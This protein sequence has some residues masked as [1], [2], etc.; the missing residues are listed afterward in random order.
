MLNKQSYIKNLL[1]LNLAVLFIS[2]S[3]VLGRYIDLPVPFIIFARALLAGF[4]LFSYAKYKG[5]NFTIDSKDKISLLIGGAFLG[6]H[7][8]TYFYALKLSNVAI[9]LI[10]LYTFPVIT[11]ILEPIMLKQKIQKV[12]LMLGLVVLIGI[13]FIVPDFNLENRYFYGI[14][15][16][17]LSAVL[18]SLRNIMLKSKVNKYNQSI[19]MLYQLSAITVLLLPTTILFDN[20]Q[21]MD[22]L[23]SL[24]LLAL[25]T[26]AIGHTLFVSSI[27][28]FSIT[29]ASLISSLQ[30]IYGIIL[31]FLILNEVPQAN[32]I[33]GGGL[34]ISCVIFESIRVSQLH[35]TKHTN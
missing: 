22:Y 20:T 25:L 34:I 7:W 3:G 30:P 9:A 27:K 2:T 14:C 24:F 17:L 5:L 21:L 28:K 19:V 16:G 12:H 35:P 26:T 1:E 8:I 18:Y 6:A 33:L 15:L 10:S 31:A 29:S 32:T 11:A 4:L 23:P 13:Y